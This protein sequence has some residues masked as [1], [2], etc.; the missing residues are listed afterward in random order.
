MPKKLYFVSDLHFGAESDEKEKNK[1]KLLSYFLN[2]V[3]KDAD[4]LYI[5]GDLFDFW[6]E[7]KTVVFAEHVEVIQLLKDAISQG[8]RV[9]YVAGNHDFWVGDYLQ[10]DVGLHI[11]PDPVYIDYDNKR[12]Y[13]C[14]GDGIAKKDRGYRL[15]KRVF[16]NKFNI[17]LYRLLHPD[18]GI[19]LAKYISGSSRK[20]T[21]NIDL[22]DHGD[23]LEYAHLMMANGKADF[24]FMGHRHSPL[25]HEFND[26]TIYI[27]LGDWLFNYTY[28]TYENGTIQLKSLKE[29]MESFKT[30]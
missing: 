29:K 6:F 2:E 23:Y 25:Q 10:N 15:M 11:Y 19:P 12:F 5:I 18:I 20:Y 22:D 14:H 30:R 1:K 26:G 28:A 7:Y 24:S 4:E 16:R 27:N 3:C 21:S 8:L 13:L 9:H 17:R